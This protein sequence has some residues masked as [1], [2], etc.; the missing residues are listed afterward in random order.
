MCAFI[1]LAWNMH[2]YVI[3]SLAKIVNFEP[4]FSWSQTAWIPII[5][6]MY[7]YLEVFIQLSTL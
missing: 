5:G 7:E 6:Q 1:D 4:I 3:F 2:P